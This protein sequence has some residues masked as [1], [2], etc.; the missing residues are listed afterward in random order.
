MRPAAGWCLW[1][2][3]GVVFLA[4]S[5]AAAAAGAFPELFLPAHVAQGMTAPP[6]LPTLM[7]AQAIFIMAFCPLLLRPREGRPLGGYLLETVG[8][9]V[10]WLIVSIP[11]YAVAGWL[12]DA[13]AREVARGV[14]YLS[15]VAAG[16]W[17]LGLW[18]GS[19]RAGLAAAAVL[20]ALM[21]AVG[22]PVIHY[23]AA[24]LAESPASLWWLAPA[25]PATC[26]FALTADRAGPWHPHPIWAWALWPTIGLLAAFARTL[27]RPK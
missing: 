6:A 23:V 7:A 27:V 25:A 16:A 26:A 18:V 4:F 2:P 15:A 17:G 20:A 21:A 5:A 8:E 22:L 24:E 19:G 10:L 14:L 3:A 11:L 1:R 13:T 9:Y 12:S